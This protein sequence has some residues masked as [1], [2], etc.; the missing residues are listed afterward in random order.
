MLEEKRE[1]QIISRYLGVKIAIPSQ[2]EYL[3][4]QFCGK[5]SPFELKTFPSSHTTFRYVDKSNPVSLGFTVSKKEQL[6]S[7]GHYF[8]GKLHGFGYKIDS[9]ASYEGQF[10]AGQL[11]GLGLV[12]SHNR[13]TFGRYES[14][15]LVQPVHL[16]ERGKEGIDKLKQL[17]KKEHIQSIYFENNYVSK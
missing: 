17:K 12:S 4:T 7:Y 3:Q 5:D 14:G 8:E 1:E 2:I 11:Q 15:T 10:E 9:N 13:F 6:M 16:Q